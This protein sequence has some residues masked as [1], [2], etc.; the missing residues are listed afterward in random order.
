MC[1]R[2]RRTN[3]RGKSKE[4]RCITALTSTSVLFLSHAF[5]PHVLATHARTRKPAPKL[6]PPFQAANKLSRNAFHSDSAQELDTSTASRPLTKTVGV[7][8][9]PRTRWC[10]VANLTGE[11]VCVSSSQLHA[12]L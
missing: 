1:G 6:L 5:M 12:V 8:C 9:T 11:S 3:P 10:L 2:L 7:T 4:T